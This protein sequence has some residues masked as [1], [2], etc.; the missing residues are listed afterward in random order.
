ML[1][2]LKKLLMPSQLVV[3]RKL[4]ADIVGQSRQLAFFEDLQ[5]RDDLDGRFDLML[6]HLFAVIVVL[7]EKNSFSQKHKAQAKELSVL[8]QE[9]LLD[10]M[11]RSLREMG[12]GDMSV[13]KKVKD[14]G[15]AWFGRR[16][17]YEQA[18]DA[19]ENCKEEGAFTQFSEAIARNIYKN[20]EEET[21]QEISQASEKITGYTLKMLDVLMQTPYEDYQNGQIAWPRVKEFC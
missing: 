10:D 20:T 13:G 21:P 14:M 3:A 7:E 5:V 4:Y 16:Q 11:D 2:F 8:I 19:I 12:V 1:S 9:A 6:V 18:F 17:A 15:A